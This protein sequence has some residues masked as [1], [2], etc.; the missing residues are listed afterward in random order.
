MDTEI[1]KQPLNQFKEPFNLENS[2]MVASETEV[3]KELKF[4]I[5]IDMFIMLKYHFGPVSSS[6]EGG[7]TFCKPIGVLNKYLGNVITSSKKPVTVKCF[8]GSETDQIRTSRGQLIDLCEG[9]PEMVQNHFNYGFNEIQQ[10]VEIDK[11]IELPSAGSFAIFQTKIIYGFLLKRDGVDDR[12]DHACVFRDDVYLVPFDHIL[13][14][15]V[16]AHQYIA[17]LFGP[18][19]PRWTDQ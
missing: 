6:A 7:L 4:K 18:G 8:K 2:L 3:D 14:E 10:A 19:K 9:R 17:Y 11:T 15:P 5:P 16:T 1:N 13:Y 12:F